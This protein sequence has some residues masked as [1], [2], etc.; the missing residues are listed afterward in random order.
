MWAV[1]K[2]KGPSKSRE[3]LA[4]YGPAQPRRRQEVGGRGGRLGP[5]D[6][7]PYRPANRP[8][9]SNQ[10]LPEILDGRHPPGGSRRDT[11]RRHRTGAGGDWGCGLG[12]EKARRTRGECARQAPG[13]LSRSGGEGTKH[14]RNRV[15][16]F[17][18]YPKSGTARNTGPAPYRAAG[19]LSGIDGDAPASLQ[20]NGASEPERETTSAR[21]CQGRN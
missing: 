6:R 11:G 5:K 15:L 3:V 1:R 16:A 13:C 8:P 2:T 20:C 12:G 18:E 4:G 7:S 21:L 17:V 10:R 9:V 19:S 14:R